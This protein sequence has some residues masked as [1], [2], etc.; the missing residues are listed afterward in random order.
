MRCLD[1]TDETKRAIMKE[2]K[3]IA[4]LYFFKHIQPRLIPALLEDIADI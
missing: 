2:L 3:H 1:V 4:K